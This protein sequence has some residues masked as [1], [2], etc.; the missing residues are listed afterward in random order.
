MVYRTKIEYDV[1][2]VPQD[3]E[4]TVTCE[5]D[6]ES[7]PYTFSSEP[8][9]STDHWQVVASAVGTTSSPG[10]RWGLF[11]FTLSATGFVPIISENVDGTQALT[12]TMERLPVANLSDGENT[13]QI[14]D[15]IARSDIATLQ[16]SLATVATSGDYSDLDNLPTI[17]TV[18]NST[19]TLTQGGTTKGSFT[20]NQ[21]SGAT[22]ALDA[23][24]AGGIQNTATGTDS[25]TILGTPSAGDSCINIGLNS[26]TSY[27]AA[28]AIGAEYDDD[29]GASASDY[30]V[31]IGTGAASTSY[32]VAI[33]AKSSATNVS[34]TEIAIGSNSLASGIDSIAL[35]KFAEATAR[36]AYQIGEGTNNT[37]YSLQVGNYPLLDTSTGLI[38][39]ARISSN[40]ARA[41]DISTAFDAAFPVGSLYMSK[42]STCPLATL[43]PNSTWTLISSGKALWTGDGTNGGTT[44]NAGLPNITGNIENSGSSGGFVEGSGTGCFTDTTNYAKMKTHTA[45]NSSY[46]AVANKLVFNASKSNSIYGKSTTVQPPAYVV[47]VWERTA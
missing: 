38:P 39:D 7:Y 41:S 42:G 47:N 45:S 30:S 24:G 2:G 40:I 32:S 35:G 26:Q 23:G 4:P 14:K 6:A 21:S 20:L 37:A 27:D 17:P 28:I 19:I 15:S 18:N 43:I 8:T 16:S 31:A 3:V 11:T 13:Y 9:W 22:I 25:L 36:E 34:G 29:N 46:D 33:G 44:I 12:V 1:F 10:S 5:A